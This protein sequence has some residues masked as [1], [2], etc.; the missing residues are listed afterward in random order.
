MRALERRRKERN[1]PRKWWLTHAPR[2]SVRKKRHPRAMPAKNEEE[3]E[4]GEQG[5][6][7]EGME[8][9]SQSLPRSSS[10]V[11]SAR[12]ESSEGEGEGEC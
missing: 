6:K 8:Q 12:N 9:R 11:C 3:R 2:G 5:R 4:G 10:V 7:R 1:E